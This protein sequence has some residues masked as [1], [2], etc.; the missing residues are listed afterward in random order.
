MKTK[1]RAAGEESLGGYAQ[2]SEVRENGTSSGDDS[3]GRKKGCLSLDCNQE[4]L[5]KRGGDRAVRIKGGKGCIRG[6]RSS[7]REKRVSDREGAQVVGILHMRGAPGDMGKGSVLARG[8]RGGETRK[9]FAE[10]VTIQ[11]ERKEVKAVLK[12]G[13]KAI[14]VLIGG[15]LHVKTLTRQGGIGFL[16]SPSFSKRKAFKKHKLRGKNWK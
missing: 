5:K 10:A 2:I 3:L 8:K 6:G 11:R 12:S 1:S 4:D 13:G 9:C 15:S 16:V 7:T 14:R